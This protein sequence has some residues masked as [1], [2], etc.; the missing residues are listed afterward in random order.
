MVISVT[1][2]IHLNHT[3][4]DQVFSFES[5]GAS[6]LSRRCDFSASKMLSFALVPP[7]Y[8]INLSATLCLIPGE[9]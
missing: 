2:T 1:V 8:L 3:D 4:A 7:V 6:L 9:D 5:L